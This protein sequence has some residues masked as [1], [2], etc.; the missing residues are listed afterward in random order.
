MGTVCISPDKTAMFSSSDAPPACANTA[1][2]S[3]SSKYT[4]A[5]SSSTT[6]FRLATKP[7]ESS[8][9]S[10]SP[11]SLKR[12]PFSTTVA[13]APASTPACTRTRSVNSSSLVGLPWSPT[14][15]LPLREKADDAIELPRSIVPTKRSFPW[16]SLGNESPTSDSPCPTV[17][18]ISATLMYTLKDDRTSRLNS[19]PAYSPRDG[20][21]VYS[22]LAETSIGGAVTVT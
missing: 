7:A 4:A 5:L 9:S 12:K 21:T 8:G 18:T 1:T 20:T 16:R 22:A 10:V 2:T 14:T 13:L 6:T 15:V 3:S 17:T 19:S 11:P